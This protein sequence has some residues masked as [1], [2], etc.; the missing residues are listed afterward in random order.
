MHTPFRAH[1][2]TF[3]ALFTLTGLLTISACSEKGSIPRCENCEQWHQLT[4]GLARYPSPHPSNANVFAFSTIEKTPGAS[5]ANREADEDIWLGWVVSD[6]NASLNRV[7]QITG[8]E[9]GNTGDNFAPRWSPGGDQLAF[10]H[11][12]GAGVFEIWRV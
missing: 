12:T 6:S 2:R 8:D 1:A 3:V 9:M 4:V 10:V 5:D 7:W 11:S